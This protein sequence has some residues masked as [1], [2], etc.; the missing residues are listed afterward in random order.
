MMRLRDDR[1]MAG[2]G[3]TLYAVL[4]LTPDVAPDDIKT[5]WRA[6]L[7]EVHPDHG[8][9][10]GATLEVQLAYEVLSDTERRAAYDRELGLLQP[11]RR[12]RSATRDTAS[13][14]EFERDLQQVFQTVDLSM[15][16]ISRTQRLWD[17]DDPVE[18]DRWVTAMFEGAGLHRCVAN[19]KRGRRCLNRVER[20]GLRCRVHTPAELRT[21]KKCTRCRILNCIVDAPHCWHHASEGERKS[22]ISARPAGRC[23]SI[24]TAGR[25][26]SLQVSA[27]YLCEQHGAFA[28]RVFNAVYGMTPSEF[29]SA[30][31]GEAP[32]PDST[33]SGDDPTSCDEVQPAM[34]PQS[35]GQ[36]TDDRSKPNQSAIV[37]LSLLGVLL[38]VIVGYVSREQ[39]TAFARSVGDA[40]ITVASYLLAGWLLLI[41]V[42]RRIRRR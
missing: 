24:T 8:G 20:A 17:G 7:L 2:G 5:A 27:G 13:S 4:G 6:R 25:P 39:V 40:A 31:A 29:A 38:L 3:R 1:R 22:A 15:I 19:T 14:D 33:N 21:V 28:E 16:Y 41:F 9:T 34:P 18:V 10:V 12:E 36:V 35:L 42:R 23:V 11:P 30:C 32:S 26:C 37:V